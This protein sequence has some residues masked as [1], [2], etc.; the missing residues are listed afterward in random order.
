MNG[1]NLSTRSTLIT[2]NARMRTT[3]TT[4]LTIMTMTAA[5]KMMPGVT[6]M[7][8]V[9]TTVVNTSDRRSESLSLNLEYISVCP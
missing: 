4:P 9:T 2:V 1:M 7:T 8:M 3:K 6:A 5:K